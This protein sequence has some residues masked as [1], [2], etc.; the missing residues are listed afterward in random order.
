MGFRG[1]LFRPTS[2]RGVTFP[3][4]VSRGTTIWLIGVCLLVLGPV[5]IEA[6]AAN[7]WS[8]TARFPA[9]EAHQ[10]AAADERFYY[11]IENRKIAKYD[12]FTGDRLAESNGPAEHLNSGFFHEGR[13]YCAHSNFPLF[14]EH[15]IVKVL[16]PNTMQLSDFKD[17]GDFGGSLTWAV[18]RDGFWW[19]C[20]AHYGDDNANL[21]CSVPQT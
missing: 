19:C 7:G 17:F 11:A 8:V 4:T 9:K 10:A 6:I 15:S 5:P 21:D 18:R 14:P 1:T 13:L 12:R 3:K 16:D 2:F 20:F